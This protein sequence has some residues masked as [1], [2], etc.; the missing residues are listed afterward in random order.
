M[1]A[2]VD[3]LLLLLLLLRFHCH[4]RWLA[5]K[6]LYTTHCLC[7]CVLF[8]ISLAVEANAFIYDSTQRAVA[9][10]NVTIINKMI[11]CCLQKFTLIRPNDYVKKINAFSLFRMWWWQ[12]VC[13]H[14]CC[15][16]YTAS[17]V[18]IDI[19]RWLFAGYFFNIFFSNRCQYQ[20]NDC[21][22]LAQT[23]IIDQYYPPNWKYW[24]WKSKKTK[25]G[26]LFSTYAYR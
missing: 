12:L 7:L 21:Q 23:H 2:T 8:S 16:Q 11:Y 19:F 18:A 9:E 17:I 5:V 13:L 4:S 22:S 25:F 24:T 20:S 15:I 3:G 6:L 1:F 10:L 26:F 14:T